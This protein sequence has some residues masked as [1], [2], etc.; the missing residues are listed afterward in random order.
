MLVS[1][2]G[3]AGL[4][5]GGAGRQGRPEG[6]AALPAQTSYRGRSLGRTTSAISPSSANAAVCFPHQ[7]LNQSCVSPQTGNHGGL[8]HLG[9]DIQSQRGGKK[10]KGRKKGS[11][12][13]W[14]LGG[15]LL[16]ACVSDL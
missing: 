3:V 14:A 2:V 9:P 4:H 6:T 5:G 11:K 13:G 12:L 7:T 1:N 8:A 10:G 15:H 16:K